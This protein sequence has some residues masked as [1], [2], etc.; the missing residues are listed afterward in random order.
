MP[1]CTRNGVKTYYEISGEGFPLVLVHANPFDRRMF[2]YQVAH[3]ST[4][5][6]VI[7][8]D[9]R[10]YGYSDKPATPTTMTE[11]GEDPRHG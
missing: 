10:A 8:M 5:L 3:F 11:L 9:L 4:F 2:M 1:Y 6:R 7:N